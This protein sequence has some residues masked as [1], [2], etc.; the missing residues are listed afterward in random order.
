MNGLRFETSS[1]PLPQPRGYKTGVRAGA[2][3]TLKKGQ[4]L[5]DDT[6]PSRLALVR[7]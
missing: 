6:S 5:R 3:G 1:V 4:V 7:S 2:D